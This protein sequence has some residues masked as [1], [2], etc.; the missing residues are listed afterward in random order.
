MNRFHYVL[1]LLLLNIGM[2]F[3]QEQKSLTGQVVDE[4][5]NPVQGATIS[6]SNSPEKISS[7]RD[8]QFSLRY[9]TGARMTVNSVGHVEFTQTLTEQTSLTVRLQTSSEELE[10]VVVVGYGTQRRGET[11]GS[12]ASVKSE[13]FNQGAVIDAGQ[14]IQGKVAGLRIT[15]PSGNPNGNTQINL[16]GLNSIQGAVNPLVIIDGV[17]GEFN[18]VAPEDIESVD[19]MKDGS[20]AAIYGT[21]ATG[22]VIFITTKQNR[23]TDGRTSIDYNNYA[24]L[25]TLFRVPDL[26]NAEDYRRLIAEGKPYEDLGHSTNWIDEVTQNPFS[27]NHNLTLFGGNSRTNFTGSVNYRDWDGVLL[28]SGQ[29][30]LN[31]RAD[32]NHD[33]FDGK[34]RSRMQIISNTI[35]SKQGG[36]SDYMWRQAMIRNPTDRIFNDQGKWQESNAYMY[37]NPL[38]MIHESVNDRMYRETRMNGSLD[39]RPT[40]DLSFKALFSRVQDNDL[41]GTSTSFDHINTTK[42]N[43]NGTASRWTQAGVE[44]LMELTANY[45][46]QFGDHRIIGLAGYS[47]QRNQFENFNA[48]NFNFPT[49]QYSY[50]Q[51]QAGLALQN[52]LATMASYKQESTLIGYFA[53]ANYSYKEKYL[54]MASIR[55][56]GSSTFGENNKWGNFPA[57]SVGWDMAKEDFMADQKVIN[58]WKWR[59]GYGVTGT[60]AASP[61]NSQIS[62]NYTLTEGAYINGNWVPGFVPARN[63]NPDLRWERKNELNVGADFSLFNNRV[64]GSLD[65]YSRQVKDLLYMFQVPVPPYLTSSMFLN[66]GE[67]SNSGFEALVNVDAV[68][69]ERFKWRTTVVFSSNKN[70][71]RNLSNDRFGVTQEFFD[72]G[73]TGEPIQ[74]FTHRVQVGR[75]IGDFY[76]YKTVG[77]DEEGKWLIESQ[78]GDIIPVQDATIEDRQYYG[79]GIPDF[80]LGWNNSFQYGNLDM[81]LNWRGSFGHQ[82]LNMS[83]LYYENPVNPAYNALRTAYDPVYGQTL[84][85]DLVYVSHYIENGDFLKLDNVTIGYTFNKQLIKGIKSLRI[86]VS[87]LNLVTITGYKGLDPE[88]TSYEGD[89]QFAPGIE[90]RDRYPTTRTYTAGL[91]VRF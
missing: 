25:Q 44:N 9:T 66:A 6:L 37:D 35:S 83:R 91:N 73:Y 27:H 40:T 14:L 29:E 46:K 86:Y 65:Y 30:R 87:G 82:I 55:R 71:L 38:G 23:S 81:T 42:N 52:G 34:L 31:V 59:A 39:Y 53:R 5:G 48:Y 74:T 50:N 61:Y 19:V 41:T 18:S 21:R 26:L 22:G 76:V 13:S 28:K 85:N 70:K 8:G 2:V 47:W 77:V 78:E 75:S 89:F 58:Q 72:T 32:L 62:Y 45:N 24:S 79:N 4:A 64:Y 3:G 88:A 56:E 54:L 57:V 12:V 33:M 80:N 15:T 1:F 7:N 17:P 60:I 90:H 69:K 49:D 63:F 11:T 20:A 36:S 43:L 84:N 67:M 68:N 51:L 16:R 10:Q